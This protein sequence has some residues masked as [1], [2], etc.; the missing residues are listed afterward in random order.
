MTAQILRIALATLGATVVYFILGG[1]F[2][3]LSP[4]KLEFMKYPSVY[5]SQEE[6]KRVWPIGIAGMVLSMLVLALLYSMLARSGSALTDGLRFGAL[7]GVYSVGSFVLHNHVNLKIGSRLTTGQAV[8][9]FVQWTIV[10]IVIA[11]IAR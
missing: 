2:F 9:Y 5:R 7:I 8:A 4:L 10:G 11:E 6:M 1:I 3:A